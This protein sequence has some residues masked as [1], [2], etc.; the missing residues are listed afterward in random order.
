MRRLPH[1]GARHGIIDHGDASDGVVLLLQGCRGR[2]STSSSTCGCFPQVERS[3]SRMNSLLSFL[4]SLWMA[5]QANSSLY[6]WQCL[7][8]FSVASSSRSK[9]GGRTDTGMGQ[10]L[11]HLHTQETRVANR[12]GN[13]PSR[14]AWAD[15]PRP[16]P[17]RFGC[18]FAPVGPFD[19]LHFAPSNCINLTTSSSRLR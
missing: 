14:L 11:H 1:Q 13:G 6:E 3:S 18:P 2:A 5:S 19:I 17:D 9:N 7:H 12:H 16:I 4:S 8:G 15:R 10:A